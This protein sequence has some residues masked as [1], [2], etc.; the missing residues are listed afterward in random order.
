VDN[1]GTGVYDFFYEPSK[2]LVESPEAF[3]L[4]IVKGT[5]S[6][7]GKTI[8]AT[9]GTASR[10]I[11]SV[12]NLGSIATFDSSYR[13][14]RAQKK[15]KQP[16]HV[17]EGLAMGVM[18]FGMGL[19]K[20]ITGIVTEPIKGVQKEK[21]IFGLAKGIGRGLAGVV[22]KPVVGT[23]D[24]VSQT[25]KGIMN[26]PKTIENEL[27]GKD[28]RKY[29]VRPPRHF[30]GDRVLHVF[31]FDKAFGTNVLMMTDNGKLVSQFYSKHFKTVHEGEFLLMTETRVFLLE[32]ELVSKTRY[33]QIW[34]IPFSSITQT[35]F[36]NGT[37]TFQTDQKTF[38]V[39]LSK[40]ETL[41]LDQWWTEQ[42]LSKKNLKSSQS[43][44]VN[45]LI[46]DSLDPPGTKKD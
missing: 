22:T 13:K 42:N 5:G 38:T 11:D 41:N 10:V 24:L 18:D 27:R 33:Q 36:A 20:G 35:R 16:K 1:L 21:N 23:L 34:N 14:D 4:G 28:S 25:T 30:G 37:A 15:L 40:E 43:A 6:L 19:A 8:S 29:R 39:S 2:G 3:G 26:T 44:R 17:G 7:I 46:F 9:F 32:L 45:S 12:A 31:D